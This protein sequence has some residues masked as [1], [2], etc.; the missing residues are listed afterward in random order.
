MAIVKTPR[1]LRVGAKGNS[2]RAGQRRLMR[3]LSLILGFFGVFL[4]VLFFIKSPEDRNLHHTLQKK[5]RQRFSRGQQ[6]EHAIDTAQNNNVLPLDLDDPVLQ[7][8]LMGEIHLVDITFEHNQVQESDEF[9]YKGL[10]GHFCKLEWNLYK[11]NPSAY[12]MFHHL[13][14]H[15]PSCAEGRYTVDMGSVVQ[16]ARAHDQHAATSS[17]MRELTF[18][19][20]VFHESRCGSTLIANML[21]AMH[22]DHHR[23]YSESSPP[24]MA[25]TLICGENYERCSEKAAARMLRD[26]VYLMSR[27]P[28]ASTEERVFFKFQSKGSRHLPA[29]RRAFPDVHRIFVYRDPVQVLQSHLKAGRNALCLHQTPPGIVAEAASRHHRIVDAH[30][31]PAGYCAAHLASITDAA[32]EAL[33]DDM[34]ATPLNYADLPERFYEEVLPFTLKLPVGPAELHQIEQVA[35][36]YSKGADPKKAGAF[37]ADSETKNEMASQDVKDAAVTFLEESYEAL[38]AAAQDA[39]ERNAILNAL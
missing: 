29:F 6:P 31:T 14:E 9:Q 25:L 32:V 35:A 19:A 30:H 2:G 39:K 34:L 37:V 20:A 5:L 4:M 10:T 24:L 26:T 18:T 16:A 15:S 11:S 28:A 1:R 27:V 36:Q 17:G 23:V 33:Q 7:Q 8:I 3:R 12:S 22:P 13:V 38:E 21:T